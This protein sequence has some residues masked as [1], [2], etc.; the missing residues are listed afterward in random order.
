MKMKKKIFT[1]AA[2]IMAVLSCTKQKLETTYSSQEDKIDSFISSQLASN[3]G[4]TVTHNNG[5]NRLTLTQG[6]GEALKEGGTIS[7]FY[8][9]YVFS[10]GISTSNL[11]DTNHEETAVA[12]QWNVTDADFS[13]RTMTLND[14]NF[15]PGLKNGLVGVKGGEICYIIFSGKYGFGKR[16]KGT[17]P[18]NSALAYQIWVE[19]ISNE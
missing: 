1:A 11:F 12:A 13:V 8:A 7:F 2:C 15:I 3:E 19:S 4:S 17:I 6:E 9:G 14:E 10:S 5:S 18:A 16:Q